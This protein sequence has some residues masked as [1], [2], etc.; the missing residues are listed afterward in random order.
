[1]QHVIKHKDLKDENVPIHM[2]FLDKPFF[3]IPDKE[4]TRLG[5]RDI[6]R[7]QVRNMRSRISTDKPYL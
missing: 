1:M 2:H 7:I 6:G 3:T 4:I 5:R